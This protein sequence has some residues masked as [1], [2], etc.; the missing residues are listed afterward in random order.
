MAKVELDNRFGVLL[1]RVLFTGASIGVEPPATVAPGASVF[2][3]TD[4]TGSVTYSTAGT[5][6]SGP[7]TPADSFASA[8]TSPREAVRPFTLT[9]KFAPNGRLHFSTRDVAAGLRVEVR[10]DRAD[11]AHYTV[12]RRSSRRAP[13]GPPRRRVVIGTSLLT[14]LLLLATVGGAFAYGLGGLS[15][16]K[17]LFSSGLLSAHQSHQPHQPQRAKETPQLALTASQPDVPAGSKVMLIATTNV[18][19][20]GG[21]EVDIFSAGRRQT[22]VG[23]P[24]TTGLGCEVS[25]TSASPATIS[26][27]AMLET[28]PQGGVLA[29]SNSVTVIWLPART[30]AIQLTSSPVPDSS[31]TVNVTAGAAVILTAKTS[32]RVDT[33]HYQIAFYDT[34]GNQIGG[35]CTRGVSCS[36]VV[37]RGSAGESTYIAY[38]DP[39]KSG[40][41]RVPSSRITVVW[42]KPVARKGSPPPTVSLTATSPFGSGGSL[43]V[44]IGVRVTLTATTSGPVDTT[45]YLSANF[46]CRARCRAALLPARGIS[47]AEQYAR[48]HAD[49]S[50]CWTSLIF[51]RRIFLLLTSVARAIVFSILPSASWPT[52]GTSARWPGGKTCCPESMPT[53]T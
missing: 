46:E 45:G 36:T 53:A 3:Q 4:D 27:Q 23:A 12:S 9:W 48:P 41:L 32:L 13:A 51:C 7:G 31:G 22:I 39:T 43:A 35:A 6:D 26:Y 20:P 15:T 42:S 2:W 37:T 18:P 8:P 21:Y 5:S 25:V 1:Q 19:I 17:D 29:S 10:R 16:V 33:V 50:W 47:R 52:T 14:G 30:P 11:G 40:D 28:G 38:A 24:C 34:R 44:M 49:D